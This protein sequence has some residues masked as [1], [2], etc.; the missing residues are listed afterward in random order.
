MNTPFGKQ[1]LSLLISTLSGS[2]QISESFWESHSLPKT[3]EISSVI[4]RYRTKERISDDV[5]VDLV[6]DL[7]IGFIMYQLLLK[8]TSIDLD[9]SLKQGIELVVNGMRKP[10]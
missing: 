3:Q 4:D 6:S 9:A 7:L 5:N 10:D 2:S 1:M 8:P